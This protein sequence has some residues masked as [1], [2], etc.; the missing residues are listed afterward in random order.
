MPQ[1]VAMKPV[2]RRAFLLTAA[3]PY[4]T[5]IA[6]VAQAAKARLRRKDCFFGIHL[7]R[8]RNCTLERAVGSLGP[9]PSLFFFLALRTLLTAD[10]QGPLGDIDIEILCFDSGKLRADLDLLVRLGDFHL[11]CKDR[12]AIRG[13]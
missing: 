4:L 12:A 8:E 1:T 5:P 10:R 2:P 9:M 6:A 13:G 3:L 7:A 11:W